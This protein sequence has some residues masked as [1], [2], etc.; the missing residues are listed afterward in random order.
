MIPAKPNA[1]H[2]AIVQFAKERPNT[3]IVT[4]NYDGCI[5]EALIEAA[6]PINTYLDEQDPQPGAVDLIKMHGSIN[7][8]YCDSCHAVRQFDLLR[9]KQSFE[10]DTATYAVIGICRACGGQRRPLLVPPMA[11]KF[12][13]FP[14]LIRLWNAARE[15]IEQSDYLV[16]VGH[17][18]SE[19]DAYISKIISRS[20]TV[21]AHQRMI[22]CDPAAHI[23]PML[24]ERFSAH[25][26][27]F[28]PMRILRAGG[29]CDEVLPDVLASLTSA[30][31][32]SPN[33]TGATPSDG[34]QREEAT[35]S[36]D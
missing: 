36:A 11:F 1:S 4:T 31:P 35:A 9:L 25:I 7:W 23:V 28:D 26:D 34:P 24:R 15:R 29:S 12:I 21:N 18:F 30:H 13:I 16:V 14:N 17:S 5:D 10:D 27:R 19:A 2:R 6:V 33:G 20:L 22:V 8:T 3:S 32:P